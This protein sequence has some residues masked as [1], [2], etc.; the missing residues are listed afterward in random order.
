MTDDGLDGMLRAARDDT[1]PLDGGLRARILADAAV[2]TA[3]APRPGRLRDWLGGVI[4]VPTAAAL[5][6]WLG[7]AQA[8]VVRAYVPGAAGMGTADAVLLDE[9]FGAAWIEGETG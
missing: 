4:G 5:G 3:P 1:A 6:L 8:D 2:Q 9:V 7:V